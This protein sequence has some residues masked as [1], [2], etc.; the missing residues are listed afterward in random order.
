MSST[1][2]SR[3]RTEKTLSGIRTKQSQN[4]QPHRFWQDLTGKPRYEGPH[5]LRSQDEPE[6]KTRQLCSEGLDSVSPPFL[7]KC[8]STDIVGLLDHTG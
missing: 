1:G 2:I 3:E 8:A 5:R 4:Q 7:C 6:A